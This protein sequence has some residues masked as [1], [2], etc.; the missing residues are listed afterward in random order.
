VIPRTFVRIPD[1]FYQYPCRG[2]DLACAINSLPLS[3]QNVAGPFGAWT[4]DGVITL[5]VSAFNEKFLV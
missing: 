1:P 4:T 3:G 2:I 5:V